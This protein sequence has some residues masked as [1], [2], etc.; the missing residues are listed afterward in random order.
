MATKVASVALRAFQELPKEVAAATGWKLRQLAERLIADGLVEPR[1][2][3]AKRVQPRS[4][5]PSEAGLSL[6]GGHEVA[7]DPLTSYVVVNPEMT[8]IQP[9][10]MGVSVDTPKYFFITADKDGE[11][12]TIL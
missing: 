11:W 3:K 8:H 1:G 5:A 12:S 10:P 9:S 4:T 6:N 2:L 7:S